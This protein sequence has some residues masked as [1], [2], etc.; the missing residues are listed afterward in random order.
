MLFIILKTPYY[1]NLTFLIIVFMCGFCCTSVEY[2]RICRMMAEDTN[3]M[4]AC[5]KIRSG[6]LPMEN[7]DPQ[8]TS[9]GKLA[10]DSL[11]QQSP[12]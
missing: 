5:G 4:F 1:G 2:L 12:M 10:C 11:S 6:F 3:M 7:T 9:I 8:V